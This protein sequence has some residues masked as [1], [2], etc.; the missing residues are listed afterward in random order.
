[1]VLLPSLLATRGDIKGSIRRHRL[2][3]LTLL[4][5]PVTLALDQVVVLESLSTLLEEFVQVDGWDA[6]SDGVIDSGQD[7]HIVC[8][9]ALLYNNDQVK[10]L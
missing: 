9:I 1:M 3:E 2:S 4:A 6:S 7:E 8:S 5:L 10:C